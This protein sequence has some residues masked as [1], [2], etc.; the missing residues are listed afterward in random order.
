MQLR[1]ELAGDS[2]FRK[3]DSQASTLER[4]SRSVACEHHRDLQTLPLIRL[5][6]V[7]KLVDSLDWRGNDDGAPIFI[8]FEHA[9]TA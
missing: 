8:A 6:V 1:P 3:A 7:E 5:V 2:A 9:R 4:S